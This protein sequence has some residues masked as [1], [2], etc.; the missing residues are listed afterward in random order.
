MIGHDGQVNARAL[1]PGT[2]I[3][4]RG[5]T[6][7]FHRGRRIVANDVDGMRRPQTYV[8]PFRLAGEIGKRKDDALVGVV[9]VAVIHG[10]DRK[11]YRARPGKRQHAVGGVVFGPAADPVVNGFFRRPAASDGDIDRSRVGRRYRLV[12][13]DCDG[14]RGLPVL[15]DFR[16]ASRIEFNRILVSLDANGELVRIGN[17]P[18]VREARLGLRDGDGVFLLQLGSAVSQSFDVERNIPVRM[19]LPRGNREQII[20]RSGERAVGRGGETK[21]E[22]II[23]V[24][25]AE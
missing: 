21:G 4:R 23:I 18:A 8:P 6:E 2:G 17:L 12:D 22:I 1:F 19:S 3:A 13:V 25:P 14:C 11:R 20:G 24:I 5:E 7:G 16:V 9:H 15:S 10:R